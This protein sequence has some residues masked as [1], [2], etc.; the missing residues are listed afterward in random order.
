MTAISWADLPPPDATVGKVAEMLRDNPGTRRAMV[1]A[2]DMA[3]RHLSPSTVAKAII[4]EDDVVEEIA[5]LAGLVDEADFD[6]MPGVSIA[7]IETA[8]RLIAE[9]DIA[10]ARAELFDAFPEILR[11]PAAEDRL[12]AARRAAD[13]ALFRFTG[14]NPCA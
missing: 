4:D 12:V 5:D 1:A 8:W 14:E 6:G 7:A 10:A 3:A 9:G 2:L 13:P 11:A